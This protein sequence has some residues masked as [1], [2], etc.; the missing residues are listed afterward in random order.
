[1]F[2]CI[3]VGDGAGVVCDDNPLSTLSTERKQSDAVRY[4]ALC[5]SGVATLCGMRNEKQ[6]LPET[7]KFNTR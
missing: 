3:P 1:M 2:R 7:N 5:H 4:S 6:R